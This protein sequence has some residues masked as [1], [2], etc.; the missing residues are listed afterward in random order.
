TRADACLVLRRVGIE[1]RGSRH[2]QGDREGGR[3]NAIRRE[4]AHELLESGISA[5][6]VF[7]PRSEAR[8][9]MSVARRSAS[10]RS[11]RSR[12]TCSRLAAQTAEIGLKFA[13]PR[14]TR[15]SMSPACGS[16]AACKALDLLAEGRPRR[17]AS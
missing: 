14:A 11:L 5:A 12:S 4:L 9:A 2:S 10:W 16:A 3:L 1:P 15:S 7:P 13:T 8:L 17:P 6:R